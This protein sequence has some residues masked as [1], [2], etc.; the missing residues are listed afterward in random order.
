MLP[1]AQELMDTFKARNSE[2]SAMIVRACEQNPDMKGRFTLSDAEQMMLGVQAMMIEELDERGNDVRDTYMNTVI[3][4]IISQ[5]GEANQ[6]TMLCALVSQV[7]FNA[8]LVYNDLIPRLSA[9]HQD[10]AS[11]FF[12]WWYARLNA[13]ITQVGLAIIAR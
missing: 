2:I 6:A 13:E 9:A 12:C 8:V 1:W 11:Y 10:D 3:P 5:G 4:G 7:T